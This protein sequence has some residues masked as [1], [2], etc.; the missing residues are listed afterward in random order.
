[1]PFLYPVQQDDNFIAMINLLCTKARAWEYEQEVRIPAIG[2]AGIYPF[3]PGY[4]C[5]IYFGVNTRDSEVE[6]IGQLLLR[7]GYGNNNV[8]IG[9]MVLSDEKFELDIKPLSF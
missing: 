7:K 8:R 5:E 6:E 4:V 2:R 9:K 1:L 3:Q